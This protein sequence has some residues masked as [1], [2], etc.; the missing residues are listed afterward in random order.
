MHV[1]SPPRVPS[2]LTPPGHRNRK[3]Q[4]LYSAIT[5][6]GP[7]WPTPA[8]MSAC[9]DNTSAQQTVRCKRDGWATKTKEQRFQRRKE[10]LAV[11]WGWAGGASVLKKEIATAGAEGRPVRTTP[12]YSRPRPEKADWQHK[13]ETHQRHWQQNSR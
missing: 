7:T 9:K 13:V 6:P 10:P 2:T 12:P 5:A 4:R 8:M 3:P 11:G 1:F